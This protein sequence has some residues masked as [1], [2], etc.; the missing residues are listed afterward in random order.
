MKK[1]Q[2]PGRIHELGETRKIL[3]R[4]PMAGSTPSGHQGLPREPPTATLSSLQTKQRADKA[5]HVFK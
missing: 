3:K 2:L 1:P 4:T 5:A